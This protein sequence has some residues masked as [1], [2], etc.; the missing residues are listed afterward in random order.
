[1][2]GFSN[3]V[4]ILPIGENTDCRSEYDI[5]LCYTILLHD[6]CLWDSNTGI[7]RIYCSLSLIAGIKIK[8]HD[9][10]YDL[11]LSGQ[12]KKLALKLKETV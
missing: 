2:I 9:M 7:E 1:M 8:A 10:V 5:C 4:G 3:L 6:A 11:S 12:I